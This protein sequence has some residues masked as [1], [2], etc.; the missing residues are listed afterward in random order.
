M[1]TLPALMFATSLASAS[2][3]LD[4]V[5]RTV[6]E[7]LETWEVAGTVT[8][9]S[10]N[11]E[12]RHLAA[13]G[14]ADIESEEPMAEDTLFWI[15][16]MTKP[17]TAAAVMQQVEAGQIDLDAPVSDYLPAFKELKGPDG[18]PASVTLKQCLTH[19][20]GLADLEPGEGANLRTLEELIPLVVSK[21]L[22]FAPGS[23]WQ[24][25]Q[26]SINTA[27]RVVEVVAGQTFP[28]YLHEHF[29]KPLGMD[30]TSFYPTEKQAERLATSYAKQENG[31]LKPAVLRF[32]YGQPVTSRNRYPLANG[33]LFSTARD[34]HRFCLMLLGNGEFEGQRYLKPESV[35][36]MSSIQTDGLETGFTPGNGWGIGCCV[37]KQPQGITAALSPGSYGHGGAYGT[38]AWI[39]PVKKRIYLLM[40]QRANFP[41]SDGSNLRRDF[42]NA[43]AKALDSSRE[44]D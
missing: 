4:S 16:S 43:A 20:S 33:G 10:E 12:I 2:P 22:N 17:V 42:Q 32:L 39:D 11:G 19:T 9:V 7:A 35:A 5:T 14:Y 25:C 44:G 18:K 15:A 38:Q 3:T 30:D 28:D 13:Q 29:F 26:S 27:A 31:E 6:A 8:L 37:V 1:K 24:Y 23:K 41:N 21:P 40:V 34:Y 36:M